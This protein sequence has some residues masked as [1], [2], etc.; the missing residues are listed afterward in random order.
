MK[1][2]Y[3][4]GKTFIYKTVLVIFFALTIFSSAFAK[5]TG[6]SLTDVPA[7][8]FN[9]LETNRLVLQVNIAANGSGDTLKSVEIVNSAGANGADQ[10][11]DISAVK[12]WYQATGGVFNAGS[13][14]SL[15]TL[16][17]SSAKN[18]TKSS[19]SQAVINGS[20]LYVTVDVSATPTNGALCKFGP[21]MSNNKLD[22][23]S[24]GQFPASALY[25]TSTQT[26]ITPKFI[27][28]SYI[29]RMPAKADLGQANI[30]AMQVSFYNTAT[31]TAQVNAERL[32]TVNY[33]GGVL[34]NAVL[35]GIKFSDGVTTYAN[36]TAVGATT[37]VNV[38]FTTSL[39]VPA[40]TTKSVD[41]Y[42]DITNTIN[43]YDLGLRVPQASDTTNSTRITIM[44]SD[45]YAFP[46][47]STRVIITQANNT[48]N[49]SH[50]TLMPAVVSKGQS[51]IKP[52]VIRFTHPQTVTT[53][54]DC[55]IK[56]VTITAISN[57]GASADSMFSGMRIS[58]G[59]T[60]FSGTPVL[61]AVS[62]LA[63]I[64]FAQYITITANTY[65]E[66]TA[67]ADIKSS[68]TS[69]NFYMS[70]SKS[71]D[72]WAV[73][74]S[75]GNTLNVVMASSL[76]STAASIINA[77]TGVSVQHANKMPAYVA[78]LQKWVYAQD[79][80]LTHANGAGYAP[81]EIKGVTLTVEN[82][83]GTNT[84]NSVLAK[85]TVL[86][87]LNNTLVSY[88]SMASTASKLYVD[89]SSPLIIP[90]AGS[91][92]LKFYLD[93]TGTTSDTNLKL[94]LGAATAIN[95]VDYYS[96]AAVAVSADVSDSFPMKTSSAQIVNA[97]TDIKVR[98]V[99][100]M[101][102]KCNAGQQ[103]VAAMSL[104]FL[105]NTSG[106]VSI[107]RIRVTIQD[108]LG[109][110]IPAAD[111]VSGV[112]I[113]EFVNT[114]NVY[115]G[116]S[117]TTTSSVLDIALAQPIIIGY[118]SAVP[119]TA[120][121]K[122]NMSANPN[123]SY[124][125]IQL[126]AAGNITAKDNNLGNS[127]TA[128]AFAGDSYPMT[129]SASHIEARALTIN[130]LHTPIAGGPYEKGAVG[131]QLMNLAFEVPG[132]TM[133]SS[134]IIRGIT[135][136]AENSSGFIGANTAFS[137]MSVFETINPANE[138][139]SVS[140]IPAGQN[141]YIN[142]TNPI[143]L[144]PS[145]SPGNITVT[146]SADISS[147]ASAAE[148]RI[149]L[150]GAQNLSAVDS[151]QLLPVSVTANIADSF[152]DMRS[153]LYTIQSSNKMKV[154]HTS[155]M[156]AAATN[157]QQG[158]KAMQLKFSNTTDRPISVRG[159]TITVEDGSNTPIIPS[160]EITKIYAVDGAGNTNGI[161]SSIPSSGSIV[162]IPFTTV[163]DIATSSYNTADI[164][165]DLKDNAVISYMKLNADIGAV[166]AMP[167]TILVEADSGDSFP[168]RSNAVK[169][170]LKPASGGIAH[171]DVIP[172][173]VSTGQTDIFAEIL[174][175]QNPN[176]ADS[177]SIMLTGLTITV[178]DD[179]NTA[180]NPSTAIKKIMVRGATV[181][182]TFYTA[183]PNSTGSFYVPFTIPA[184]VSPGVSDDLKLYVDIVDTLQ[185]GTFRVNLKIN[186][187]IRFED[188]NSGVTITTSAINGD[189]FPM[190]TSTVIIQQQVADCR[191]SHTGVIQAAY[192]RGQ[193]GAKLMALNFTNP[194]GISGANMAI[195]RIVI[196]TEDLSNAGITPYSAL[197][198][199]Y[200]T[201]SL[202]TI[203]GDVPSVADYGDNV[204]IGLTTPITVQPGATKQV[205]IAGDINS[206]PATA[207][208]KVNL[209]SAAAIIARDANSYEILPVIA[210]ADAFPMRS[211]YALIQQKS[212]S[213][214]AVSSSLMPATVNKGQANVAALY[215]EPRNNNPAGY[216]SVELTG[217]T[218]TVLSSGASPLIP[219][220]VIARLAV[221]DGV[222]EYGS[223]TSMPVSGSAVYVPFTTNV[224]LAAGSAKGLTLYAD[225]APASTEIYVMLG[226]EKQQDI[227]V[228]EINS[229]T[230][231]TA[232]TAAYPLR[233]AVSTILSTPGLKISHAALAPPQVTAGEQNFGLIN[234]TSRNIGSFTEYIRYLTVTVK[235]GLGNN[236]AASEI[237]TNM[238]LVDDAGNTKATAAVSGPLHTVILD[239]S[240][241][242]FFALPQSSA[243][244]SLYAD[245]KAATF[246]AS[247]YI[248]LAQAQ[249]VSVTAAVSADG[250]EIFPMS[251]GNFLLQRRTVSVSAVL[252]D[253][254]PP[255]V[256]TGQGDVFAM[257]LTLS[258]T[259]GAGFS[260]VLITGISL[261]VR[262]A[263]SNTVA[264]NMAVSRIKATDL[265]DDYLNTTAITSSE[266]IDF[267]FPQPVT[268]AAGE[269]KYVYIVADITPNTY[270]AVS[271]FKFVL[272]SAAALTAVDYNSG[273]LP[274]VVTGV[275][276][277]E[278]SVAA[279]QKQ[280]TLLKVSHSDTM[281]AVLSTDQLNAPAMKIIFTDTGDTRTAS[282]MVTRVNIYLEDNTNTAIAP[283]DV[284]KAVRI[285]SE[286]GSI[287]YGETAS[288]TGNKITINL[289]APIIV[290][291]ANNVTATVRVDAA[292]S[293][294]SPSFK[295]ALVSA[296]DVYAVDANSFNSVS[297]SNK[298]P[299]VFPM[300]SGLAVMQDKASSVDIGGFDPVVDAQPAVVKAQKR[301]ALFA[302]KVS[303]NLAAGTA[304]EIWSGLTITVKNGAG[305]A[306]IAA[307]SCIENIY[308]VDSASATMASVAPGAA[309]KIPV[310]FS[311]PVA[312]SP[313]GYKYVTVFA[314]ILPLATAFNFSVYLESSN[315]VWVKDTNSGY[316]VTKNITS[317]S[318]PWHTG[319]V[320]VNNAPATDLYTWHDGTLIPALVGKG[321]D[322]VKLMAL[323]LMN[324]G[325]AGSADVM[326]E[327]ISITAVDTS[328]VILTPSSMLEGLKFT[329]YFGI[330]TYGYVTG[331]AFSAAGP[332]Y[333]KFFNPMAVQA[334]NTVTVYAVA[335]IADSAATGDVRFKVASAGNIIAHNYPA[336]YVTIT[337]KNGDSF[338]FLSNTTTITAVTYFMEVGHSARMPV[339]AVK[340][341]K[342]TDALDITF[343]NSNNTNV[344]IAGITITA[345]SRDGAAIPASSVLRLITF[346]EGTAVL[347]SITATAVPQMYV[348]FT[349]LTVANNTT[350]TITV[351]V[352]VSD[353]CARDFGIELV[354]AGDVITTPLTN[355]QAKAGDYFGN[356]KSGAASIQAAITEDSY[357]S[358]PN[359]FNPSL[360]STNI[361]YYLPNASE[362]TV[363]VFTLEG[364]KVK[365]I[366]EK[367]VKTAGLH[368]E[369]SWDGKNGD[370]ADV[371]SGV[372]L[373][374]LEINDKTTGKTKKLI[375]K[376]MVLR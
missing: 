370:K 115:A 75:S 340:G 254:M 183:I 10:T 34:L 327:G 322:D 211:D 157:G 19:V 284:A 226:I 235:D 9:P 207:G 122:F 269:F 237:F 40:G 179:T 349:S 120:S 344:D 273:Q 148:F 212:S 277:M 257:M 263:A 171:S 95:S 165:F 214:A 54:A 230:A 159:V 16:T 15:G 374:V 33:A 249:D 126:A 372:Y 221:S 30:D 271:G 143:M 184:S 17:R 176:P 158:V 74:G 320:S 188:A 262:D 29:D 334:S 164:Y 369:D 274:V 185:A 291:T 116:A 248:S 59:V 335:N 244:L 105:N 51:N 42:I 4:V 149:N 224:S 216:S 152:P 365:A 76:S 345:I 279:L 81:I 154:L 307:N 302:F 360:G 256:S 323:N 228:S 107:D 177:A 86:D 264:A 242:P 98:H 261:T 222:T 312:L 135:L 160:S 7:A 310:K 25:N 319:Q 69:A 66:V 108:N 329:D 39:A 366:I 227:K 168:M 197:T 96:K 204:S 355:V 352:E 5:A 91:N 84:P 27:F 57:D 220:S 299:D 240:S 342:D 56:G 201:D 350:K 77:A 359:P 311:A 259:G 301:V 332:I 121:V 110:A 288:F 298:A 362:V 41:I 314:D 309:F 136:T 128:G 215:F 361:E 203:Y 267:T 200:V 47:S 208:F 317:G 253:L 348:E 180:I 3:F 13:A 199:M 134:V 151:N 251:S 246:S 161:V 376:I 123:K 26:I 236:V 195:T 243:S 245:A 156:P 144:T 82:D 150:S 112:R 363:A 20:C 111:V 142:F 303:D 21:S 11:V 6:I 114:S 321:Q 97:A 290:S 78:K 209:K 293:F 169:V 79:V 294:A 62:G 137:K 337:A 375:R 133:T 300:A 190:T 339:S 104:A 60:V 272:S 50:T 316:E 37:T 28:A 83:A 52:F 109:A 35:T 270:N 289:T 223:Q 170:Q 132:N 210:Q 14:L 43:A 139:G 71:A 296:P 53:Y 250:A 341:Q 94:S 45:G 318:L 102:L 162:Y 368:S 117:V 371:R 172:T 192:N 80:T 276:A 231:I 282:I 49:A 306:D 238:Y 181:V 304:Q 64:P 239:M 178:E 174:T 48:V 167:N 247:Y 373:C 198:R 70:L 68:I 313:S 193:T 241:S 356:M 55:I 101:P 205:F 367:T 130:V 225:I 173:T 353:S 324:P 67:L 315:E 106:V 189:T 90:P 140:A 124:F 260:P 354:S 24:G 213:I 358:Y 147:F 326:V 280:P 336:G 338:E 141:I 255:S 333:V 87:S 44:A 232:I 252:T 194:G 233:S 65:R 285:C 18:W 234:F 286:D 8:N 2:S 119:V 297:I 38:P 343:T 265:F 63:W 85:L 89:F 36:Y 268:L 166:D 229:S 127:L 187:D 145:A 278:S 266:F 206:S 118:N 61:S 281:P 258:N 1:K 217:V 357:H 275:F 331:S 163:V 129:S 72:V 325:A 182:N 100:T 346:K 287:V 283:A 191:M 12:L 153:F 308:I 202:G 88:S 99:D 23:S 364:R 131:V 347:K 219:S 196:T 155:L 305:T 125:R 46:F 58:D 31:F 138:L 113:D 146:V 218:V 328:N 22:F 93:V 330:T 32:Q 351:S 292:S 92:T 103:G 175:I 186:N 295:A 73:S